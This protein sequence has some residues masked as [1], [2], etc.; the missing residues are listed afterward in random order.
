M[1][2]ASHSGRKHGP[3]YG[4]TWPSQLVPKVWTALAKKIMATPATKKITALM[5]SPRD[6]NWTDCVIAMIGFALVREAGGAGAGER[7]HGGA[8]T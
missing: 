5:E 2:M 7:Q 8:P 3:G 1:P 4:Q 6:R